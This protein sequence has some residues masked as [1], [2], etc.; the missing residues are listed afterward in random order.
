MD[1]IAFIAVEN[2]MH[3]NREIKLLR[4]SDINNID[5]KIIGKGIEWKGYITKLEI[6]KKYLE[7]IDNKI[8]CITDSRDV[9]YMANATKIK[10]TY[11]LNWESGVIVFNGETNCYPDKALANEHPMQNEKYKYL[12]SGCMI[13]S[14]E[15]Y[16]N[17]LE[18]CL[19]LAKEDN[20]WAE[21]DQYLLQKILISGKYGDKIT[22][23]YGC[24]LFQIIRDEL[25]GKSNN[26]DLIYSKE[27]IY[28][29]KTN[30]Y[31]CI[32]HYPGP[33]T[34]GMQAWKVLTN[35]YYTL[36]TNNYF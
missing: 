28:N 1:S 27:H 32:F 24:K 18:D 6:I 8:I 10:E 5:I 4:S 7:S 22:L 16:I 31:P 15:L 34:V 33:T 21:N 20:K 13:G 14:R 12:N 2:E 23:D 29:R 25:T 3:G 36:N 17:I 19:E 30:T 35:N 26:F 11:E 9:L